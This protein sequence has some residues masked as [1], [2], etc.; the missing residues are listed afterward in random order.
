MNQFQPQPKKPS[1]F[2]CSKDG[3]ECDGV[4]PCSRCKALNTPHMCIGINPISYTSSATTSYPNGPGHSA[5][6]RQSEKKRKRNDGTSVPVSVKSLQTYKQFPPETSNPPTP[7]NTQSNMSDQPQI[8]QYLLAEFRKMKQDQVRL[9]EELQRLK[10]QNESLSRNFNALLKC[11]IKENP[12]QLVNPADLQSQQ[13][14]KPMVVFDLVKKTPS[15]LTANQPFCKLF[16]YKMNEV[17]GMPWNKFIHPDHIERTMNILSNQQKLNW[18]IQFVQVYRNKEGHSF[19][20]LD[21]HTFFIG[22]NGPRADLVTITPLPMEDSGVPAVTEG[23][24]WQNLNNNNNSTTP[25][26]TSNTVKVQPLSP[27]TTIEPASPPLTPTTPTFP[28]SDTGISISDQAPQSSLM[29]M[30]D[31]EAQFLSPQTGTISI[32][33]PQIWSPDVNNIAQHFVTQKGTPQTADNSIPISSFMPYDGK[34]ESENVPNLEMTDYPQTNFAEE[35]WL[36]G[37]LDDVFNFIEPDE[38]V[39]NV[40]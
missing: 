32:S 35:S 21:S 20:T 11:K 4:Q 1:C 37:N 3:M 33:P 16:G 8:N 23:N 13:Q 10:E 18:A 31:S 6:S 40:Q 5:A 39:Y 24:Y 7:S 25:T 30:V 38:R 12:Y 15:I 29:P 2:L 22:S 9:H 17:I 28:D 14:G 34:E 26:S 27:T 36:D 19:V